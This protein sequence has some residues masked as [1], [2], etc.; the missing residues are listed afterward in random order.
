MRRRSLL[1]GLDRI[2]AGN[3][4]AK[5]LLAFPIAS[6]VFT[7]AVMAYMAGFFDPTYY[8]EPWTP[9]IS[10]GERVSEAFSGVIIFGFC[11]L[12]AV[13]LV[14]LIW[15]AA[16]RFPKGI[17][18]VALG[19]LAFTAATVWAVTTIAVDESSTA[20]IGL[21]FLPP[22]LGVLLLPFAG[23]AALV[24]ALRSRRAS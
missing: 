7:I 10:A 11:V 13:A 4:W 14:V 9:G 12:P 19:C 16:H 8:T 5:A 23:V 6:A 24:H 22:A 3:R 1:S 20:A 2:T 15:L 17:P 18:V 21:L